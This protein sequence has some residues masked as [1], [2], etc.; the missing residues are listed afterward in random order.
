VGPFI[1]LIGDN[2]WKVYKWNGRF[3]MGDLV[4]KHSSESAAIKSAKKNI[5]FTNTEREEN[6]K[7]IYIWLDNEN[8]G[9]VGVIYKKL[10]G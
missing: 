7:Q 6:K 2:M 5:N 3:I 1:I 8:F 9:P 4:S 10:R